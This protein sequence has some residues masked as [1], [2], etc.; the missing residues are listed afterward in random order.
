MANGISNNSRQTLAYCLDIGA[1]TGLLSLM[2]AQKNPDVKIEAVEIEKN[3][4]GQARENFFNSKWNDRLNIFHADIKDFAPGK[5]YD[6]IITNPPFYESDLPSTQINKNIAKHNE[7]LLLKDIVQVVNSHLST[8]GSFA[9]L[10]PFH[11]AK[12]FEGIAEENKLFLQNKVSVRQTP[13]HP[14]FRVMLS[15]SRMNASIE[16]DQLTIKDPDGE[17]SKNFKALLKDYYLKL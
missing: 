10:L 17:Y 8:T 6:L 16:E 12:Y 4:Y 14:F 1:G 13:S 3:A 5:K 2:L 11:R 9:I 15:F 7:S